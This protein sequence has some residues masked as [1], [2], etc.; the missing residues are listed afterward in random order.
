MIPVCSENQNNMDNIRNKRYKIVGNTPEI[1]T[2]KL[3]I[4]EFE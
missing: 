1:L 3:I 2:N 4:R